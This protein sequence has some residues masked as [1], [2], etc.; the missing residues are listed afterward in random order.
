MRVV[1]RGHETNWNMSADKR[2]P[3]TCRQMHEIPADICLQAQKI[4][5]Y[6]VNLSAI[7]KN[8]RTQKICSL[9][10]MMSYLHVV[11]ER[12][13]LWPR[14]HRLA[15]TMYV[16]TCDRFHRGHGIVTCNW[17]HANVYM[18]VFWRFAQWM[19]PPWTRSENTVDA[20]SFTS[21]FSCKQWR[22]TRNSV[23]IGH[24]ILQ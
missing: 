13:A 15:S 5:G 7:T 21:P 3:R 12:I 6:N 11:S 10:E 2:F 14:R 1:V 16:L 18:Y 20:H 24:Y 4:S 19:T 8:V 17:M 9:A 22:E 23:D